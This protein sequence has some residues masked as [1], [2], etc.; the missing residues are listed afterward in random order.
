MSKKKKDPSIIFWGV[1][2]W[3]LFNFFKNFNND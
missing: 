3:G 1:V 2:I